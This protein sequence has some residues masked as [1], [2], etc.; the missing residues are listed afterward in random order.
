VLNTALIAPWLRKPLTE[1]PRP[2]VLLF[3]LK[4]EVSFY[5]IHSGASV[6]LQILS[7]E[8]PS[9]ANNR[10]ENPEGKKGECDKGET[11]PPVPCPDV[12]I[13]TTWT[14]GWQQGYLLM[15]PACFEKPHILPALCSRC[16]KSAFT[17]FVGSMGLG[18]CK[19]FQRVCGQLIILP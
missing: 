6:Y 10:S 11:K 13:W 8:L 12:I 19:L 3:H 18:I 17:A 15:P 2:C 9:R 4:L 1:P 5:C 7:R 14:R 16:G